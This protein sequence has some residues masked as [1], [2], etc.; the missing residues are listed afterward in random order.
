[1]KSTIDTNP[2]EC[3]KKYLLLSIVAVKVNLDT[4]L[5]QISVFYEKITVTLKTEYGDIST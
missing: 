5:Y 4:I 3:E 2:I 1:M